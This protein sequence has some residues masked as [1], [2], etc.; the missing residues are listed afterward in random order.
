VFYVFRPEELPNP[1]EFVDRWQSMARKAGLPGLYLAAEVS[2]LLGAGPKYD[3]VAKDGFDAGVY[4]RMPASR[5]SRDILRMRMRRK[6]RG[7]PEVYPYSREPVALPN[8]L[9]P[10]VHAPV[11]YPN[12]DNTPRSGLNGLVLRGASPDAFRPHLR[13][14][15]DHVARRPA[16]ERLVWIKSWNEWAEG[17]HLEPD[18]TFGRGWLDVVR[19]E[20]RHDG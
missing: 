19:D 20:L 2:D 5:A 9:D 1:A 17:N 14:A 15:I 7:G 12:W 6:L 13:A 11:V 10:T 18:L 3:D 16:E 4:V 8:S